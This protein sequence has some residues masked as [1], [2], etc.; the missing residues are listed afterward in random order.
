MQVLHILN[1]RP[2][3]YNLFIGSCIHPERMAIYENRLRCHRNY[4]LSY[5]IPIRFV[6][7]PRSC[8]TQAARSS[9]MCCV[10]ISSS[11][12]VPVSIDVVHGKSRSR[13]IHAAETRLDQRLRR[14]SLATLATQG[15]RA[16][17][18][19]KGGCASD[20]GLR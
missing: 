20:N 13:M 12:P 15:R 2:L 18:I 9:P 10:A 14:H 16:S 3:L 11:L 17:Y 7:S 19:N 6:L 4:H 5:H 8:H 1:G